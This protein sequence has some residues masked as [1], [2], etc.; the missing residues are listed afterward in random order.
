MQSVMNCAGD[1]C[2]LC[3]PATSV[4]PERA[5]SFAG[6]VVNAKRACLLPDNMN[7]LLSL[8]ENDDK[9]LLYVLITFCIVYFAVCI[10]VYHELCFCTIIEILSFIEKS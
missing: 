10:H 7:M 2:H 1:T 9:L 3:V 6:Q 4:P 8:A 5:F